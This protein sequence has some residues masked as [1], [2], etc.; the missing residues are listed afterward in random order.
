M[1]SVSHEKVIFGIIL[2]E[3]FNRRDLSRNLSFAKI[4]SIAISLWAL[5]RSFPDFA[6]RSSL[7]YT[8]DKSYKQLAQ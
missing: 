1:N 5:E 6:I 3:I 2:N 8:R 4:K 7:A